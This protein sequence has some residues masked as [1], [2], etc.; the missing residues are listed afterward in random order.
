M[1]HGDIVLVCL[2]TLALVSSAVAV[3]LHQLSSPQQARMLSSLADSHAAKEGAGR[4]K[5]D[6]APLHNYIDT[7]FDKTDY[8]GEWTLENCETIFN[9]EHVFLLHCSDKGR[10]FEFSDN[11]G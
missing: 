9:C 6:F 10:D 5:R 8:G 1:M 2:A 3:P 4:S 7:V 11:T